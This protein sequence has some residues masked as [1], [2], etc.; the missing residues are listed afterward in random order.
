MFN[1]ITY[2]M[3][4]GKPLIMYMGMLLFLMICTQVFM[5]IMVL[6]GKIGVKYHKAMGFSILIFG[7][8]H[9]FFGAMSF[10]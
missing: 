2:Y 8:I 3:I 1:N 9:G 7:A 4:F 6:Q 5:G 10:F